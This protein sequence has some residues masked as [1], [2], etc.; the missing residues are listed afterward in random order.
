MQVIFKKYSLR[1]CVA[2]IP[3]FFGNFPQIFLARLDTVLVPGSLTRQKSNI[4]SRF[5][6]IHGG[7][8]RRR[9]PARRPGSRW[10]YI[11]EIHF[12]DSGLPL[13]RMGITVDNSEFSTFSTDFSTGTFFTNLRR[14]YAFPLNITHCAF[15]KGISHFFFRRN[16]YHS[17]FFV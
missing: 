3:V 12:P 17:K 7:T 16:N 1:L 2:P 5:F 13:G 8:R 4:Y 9:N 6:P 10:I 14:V 11:P 15:C